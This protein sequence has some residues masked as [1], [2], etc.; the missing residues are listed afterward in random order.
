MFSIQLNTFAYLKDSER[1]TLSATPCLALLSVSGFVCA[2]ITGGERG[3]ANY[4]ALVLF[5]TLSASLRG[6]TAAAAVS[7]LA[8]GFRWKCWCVQL[9]RVLWSHGGRR[10]FGGDRARL[11][12]GISGPA[13]KRNSSWEFFNNA[14]WPLLSHGTAGI[15]RVVELQTEWWAQTRARRL[16]VIF[17]SDDWWYFCLCVVLKGRRCWWPVR[18]L[19]LCL[20]NFLSHNTIL[21]HSNRDKRGICNPTVVCIYIITIIR[22]Q[23]QKSFNIIG[24]DNKTA[25]A[26]PFRC[27]VMQ[28]DRNNHQM[29]Q[30]T[31]LIYKQ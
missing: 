4:S 23:I 5:R 20:I 21:C 17:V 3:C 16:N 10:V 9:F 24:S 26:S 28:S 6:L 15:M 7:E 19:V 11:L 2:R 31:I 14:M 30:F 13:P 1:T 22:W 27:Q 18:F 12:V 8:Q 25:V 29:M